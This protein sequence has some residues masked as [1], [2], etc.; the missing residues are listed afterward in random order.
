[1]YDL[2]FTKV[3]FILFGIVGIFLALRMGLTDIYE[4]RI[5]KVYTYAQSI[6]AIVFRALSIEEPGKIGFRKE[7][8]NGGSF[9]VFPKGHP[10][11]EAVRKMRPGDRFMLNLQKNVLPGMSPTDPAA[12]LRIEIFQK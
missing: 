9:I 7:S 4:K 12:Y 8:A 2:S 3:L 10:D 1:M 6:S 11:H 5:R